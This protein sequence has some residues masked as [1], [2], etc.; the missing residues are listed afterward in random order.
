MSIQARIDFASMFVNRVTERPFLSDLV[1]M[2]QNPQIFRPL[3]RLE[4]TERDED[5]A[6]KVA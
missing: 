4:Q 1:R 3:P 5:T 6:A 2:K